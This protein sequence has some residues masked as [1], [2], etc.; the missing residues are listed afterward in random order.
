MTDKEKQA[1]NLT[2]SLFLTF[3]VLALAIWGVQRYKHF[4]HPSSTIAASDE[5]A[6]ID[7]CPARFYSTIERQR[8]MRDEGIYKGPI[9]GKRGDLTITAEIEHAKLYN[10][11]C[12]R[13][14]ME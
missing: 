3:T 13:Q 4:H 9:D 10:D 14:E 1:F 12:N 2:F 6:A 5:S 7:T 8:I 11:W